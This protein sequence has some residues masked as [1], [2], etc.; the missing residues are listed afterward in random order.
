M[1]AV[2]PVF[3]LPPSAATVTVV[4]KTA[5]GTASASSDYTAV[6]P[7]TLTF[8]PGTVLQI[9][10]EPIIGDTASEPDEDVHRQFE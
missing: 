8:P 7:V 9:V 1:N 10:T 3:L 4:A 6:L 5:N 2:F